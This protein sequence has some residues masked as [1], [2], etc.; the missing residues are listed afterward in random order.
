MKS[1]ITLIPLLCFCFC[2]GQEQKQKLTKVKSINITNEISNDY[3]FTHIVVKDEN[4]IK[5][6]FDKNELLNVIKK[7]LSKIDSNK[8]SFVNRSHLKNFIKKSKFISN[9]KI[10]LLK[11]KDYFDFV[12]NSFLEKNKV[13]IYVNDEQIDELILF[14]KEEVHCEPSN[15]NSIN[16]LTFNT[17]HIYKT[18]HGETIL[19]LLI[20]SSEE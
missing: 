12:L 9:K 5:I 15:N 20:F 13:N 18:N 14:K 4:L 19:S 11:T 16:F 6:V 17:Y 1:K 7:D 10:E 2:F 8:V 3:S